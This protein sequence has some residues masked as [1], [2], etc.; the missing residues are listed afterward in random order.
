MTVLVFMHHVLIKDPDKLFFPIK[1]ADNFFFLQ[2][3]LCYGNH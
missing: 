2:E 3:N 1:Y